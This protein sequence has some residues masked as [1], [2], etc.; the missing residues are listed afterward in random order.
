MMD[1]FNA[2]EVLHKQGYTHNDIKTDNIMLDSGH[3]AV[4][5]DLGFSS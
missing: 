5:V 3:N 1:V 4:L 2:L